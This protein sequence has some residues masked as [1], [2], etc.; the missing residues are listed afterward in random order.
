MPRQV[1]HLD[2]ISQFTTDIRHVKGP[3]NAV[4]D[5]L[6]RI[7]ANALDSPPV[8]D[9][10]AM[11]AA[12]P[13]DPELQHL[14][15]GS[16]LKL[17]A[18][19]LTGSD[20]TYPYMRCV[21]RNLATICARTVFFDSLHSLSHPGIRATQCLIAAR[22]VWP[23]M[24]S[25]VRKW[26][27]SCL[28]CKRSKVHRH[29]AA[30]LGTFATPESILTQTW[31]APCP[32]HSI[33]LQP[34]IVSHVGRKLYQLRTLPQRL[35]PGHLYTLGFHASVFPPLSLSTED[36]SLSVLWKELTSKAS[37]HNLLSSHC[38]WTHRLLPSSV[39]VFPESPASAKTVDRRYSLA[40]PTPYPKGVADPL[41][42][43]R[44]RRGLVIS[45]YQS[46]TFPQES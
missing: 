18:V 7:G 3:N 37:T 29:V 2:L 4:A 27:R 32:A 17:E 40:W 15:S 23:K 44:G 38:Q 46:G 26:A 30:P 14:P 42:K 36:A 16:S 45:L 41:P 28:Q 31:L 25:D 20:G 33:S 21:H 13:G 6:S 9:F 43:K 11:A 10:A 39:E 19:P 24:N 35:W 22:Y 34:S 8:I 5:A 1:R 12:Q